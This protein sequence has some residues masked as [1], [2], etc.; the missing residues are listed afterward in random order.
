[1]P[2]PAETHS[3]V[4]VLRAALSTYGWVTEPRGMRSAEGCAQR[5]ARRSRWHYD[6]LLPTERPADRLAE[7]ADRA[8]GGLLRGVAPRDHRR[9]RTSHGGFE[10]TAHMLDMHCVRC[11][12]SRSVV[13][14]HL[15]RNG[16]VADGTERYVRRMPR[17]ACLPTGAHH[18]RS[19]PCE[20]YSRPTS[21]NPCVISCLTT[22]DTPCNPNRKDRTD[23]GYTTAA[24]TTV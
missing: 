3:A 21:S 5:A 2:T 24:A 19:R 15:W 17:A 7:R 23:S 12:Y 9:V 11:S 16:A 20:S 18:S 10:W 4:H 6:A 13:P 8:E 22:R 14:L 1:M